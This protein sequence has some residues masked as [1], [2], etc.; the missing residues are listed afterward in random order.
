MLEM[1]EKKDICDMFNKQENGFFAKANNFVY[2]LYFV[3]SQLCSSVIFFNVR[4]K[5]GDFTII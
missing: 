5:N 3:H 2:D 4:K 1:S